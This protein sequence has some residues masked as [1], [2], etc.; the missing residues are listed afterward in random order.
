MTNPAAVKDFVSIKVGD[1][2]PKK[3]WTATKENTHAFA[4][5]TPP[6]ADDPM[7]SRSP[8]LNEDRARE[9]IY[10]S[11][12]TDG[13]H[14]MSLVCQTATDWLPPDALVSGYSEVDLRFPNPCRLGD[15]LTIGGEV[16]EKKSVDG[17]DVVVLKMVAESQKGKV[18]AA[19]TIT[20]YV[21]R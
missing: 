2:V 15:T 8:H 4:S 11:V 12:W 20:A 7:R 6:P 21:P 18:V 19:G 17:R 3:V 9:E 5:L 13:N 1:V 16:V 10:G 14:T